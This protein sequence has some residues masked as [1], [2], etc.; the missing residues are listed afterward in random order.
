MKKRFLLLTI[1]IPF[2]LSLFSQDSKMLKA[3]QKGKP[4]AQVLMGNFYLGRGN[5]GDS[6]QAV[7]WYRKAAENGNE[8]AQYLLGY[9]YENGIGVSKDADMA[10]QWYKEASKRQNAEAIKALKNMGEDMRDVT[11]QE[12]ITPSEPKHDLKTSPSTPIQ[13]DVISEID[14]DI[15]SIEQTNR[16]TFVII[17]A[18]E[19]YQRE[20]KVDFA[21]NDGNSFKMYCHRVLGVPDKNIHYVA[22]GTL[23]NLIYELDWI[24][25]V[26][27]AY[28][29]DASVIFYYAG[30]GIPDETNGQ[31]YLLPIDGMGKNIRTCYSTDELY[32]TLGDLP[33]QKIIVFMDACF[34]GAKRNGDMLAAARGVAIKAKPSSPKGKMVVLSAAQGDE[35][36]YSYKEERHGLFTFFLLKKIK[37]SNGTA[38]LG[39][40]TQYVKEQVARFSIVENGKSQTPTVIPSQ[41]LMNNWQNM[42]LR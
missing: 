1:V 11:I 40:L 31:S 9:C 2:S 33:A 4:E 41:S 12:D 3:A 8:R 34:S 32:K 38:S 18:N 42:K 27:K 39:E 6:Q 22:N 28:N 14:K 10:K 15:P 7:D 24:S 19:D 37:D 17:I 16:N 26:C 25:Q 30:H 21:R 13:K 20:A 23:N 36:A 29:G 35:T 5:D